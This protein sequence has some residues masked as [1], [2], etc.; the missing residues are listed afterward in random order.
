[1]C[2]ERLQTVYLGPPPTR[3]HDNRRPFEVTWR[4]SCR[5]SAAGRRN[6]PD[7]RS[8]GDVVEE[9]GIFHRQRA[10]F[11]ARGVWRISRPALQ[12]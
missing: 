2:G 6:R 11:P 4:A 9:A 12:M 10:L 1:M 5:D 8:R 7:G 3:L